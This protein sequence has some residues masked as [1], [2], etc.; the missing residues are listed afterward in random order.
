MNTLEIF[1]YLKKAGISESHSEAITYVLKES[2]FYCD[3]GT[4]TDLKDLIDE[5]KIDQESKIWL[6]MAFG[7]LQLWIIVR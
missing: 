2:N 3:F 1:S 7:Y 6:I 4:K 5:L